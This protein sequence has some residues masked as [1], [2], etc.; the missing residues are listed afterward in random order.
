MSRHLL[1][2]PAAHGHTLIELLIVLALIAILAG[3][4]Y[5]DLSAAIRRGHRADARS[6]L[7]AIQL[8][9]ARYQG[10]HGHYA[11]R[12]EEL[13]WTVPLS[14]EGYYRLSLDPST[15]PATGFLAHA[16]PRQSD[17][18]CPDLRI[19]AQGPIIDNDADRACW[20]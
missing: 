16:R 10:S 17:E 20:R 8:A 13:G 3:I 12:L 4:A 7:Q 2:P 18:N 19:D 5:P 14:D 15:D 6:S 1:E 9:Q 11:E